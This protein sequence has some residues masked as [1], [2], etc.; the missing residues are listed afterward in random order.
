M[1]FNNLFESINLPAAN[2]K[3]YFGKQSLYNIAHEIFNSRS[4]NFFPNKINLVNSTC[5]VIKLISVYS[6][7]FQTI[8]LPTIYCR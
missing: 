7:A 5:K 4:G 3:V 6:S 2:S 8:I 1:I